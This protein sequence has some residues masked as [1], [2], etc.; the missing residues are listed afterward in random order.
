[1]RIKVF[2]SPQ[3]HEAL[4]MV[5]QELGPDALILDRQQSKSADGGALWHVHAAI[6]QPQESVGE[7][8]QHKTEA[9]KHTTAASPTNA[10][11]TA[12]AQRT[13]THQQPDAAPHDA[14]LHRLERIVEGLSNQQCST[15]RQALTERSEQEAFDHLLNMGVAGCHA[16]DMAG[17]FANKQ[18]LGKNTLLWASRI[19][20]RDHNILLFNGPSG[21]GK[22][23][24]IAKLAAHYSLKG[25]RVALVSTDTEKMGGLESLKSYA[26]TLGIPFHPL[27]KSPDAEKIL[28]QEKSAQLMLIDTEGWSPN[29]DANLKR[30]FALWNA[31]HCTRRLLML[32][33]SMD[34][35]DGMQQLNHRIVATMSD[36]V[37]S[38]LDETARP[39]K[40]VNWGIAASLPLSYCS[41]GPEV[42][43]QMG[44]LTPQALFTLLAKDVR[45]VSA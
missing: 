38:K 34:E 37:F 44:W 20:P 35:E 24:L 5:R 14:T 45:S 23:T 11:A 42:P 7:T 8:E 25:I 1:M 17:D 40:I 39:G 4:A 32:P 15:L 13:D 21:C 3:L 18:P 6:E 30:Q 22:T 43:E 19:Q 9:P 10:A 27:R 28:A 16:F 36:I 12:N 26:A 33:A 31:M 29:R 2:T 41:F